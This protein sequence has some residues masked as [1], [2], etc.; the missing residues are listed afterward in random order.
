M[1]VYT[2]FCTLSEYYIIFELPVYKN[3]PLFPCCAGYI[4]TE[5]PATASEDEGVSKPVQEVCGKCDQPID[6]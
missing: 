5:K 3:F 6:V 4:L 1:N 2:F